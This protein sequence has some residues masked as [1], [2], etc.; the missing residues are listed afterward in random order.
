MPLFERNKVLITAGPTYEPIDPVRFI[1]NNSSGKMGFALAEAFAEAGAEVELI[2]GPV[3]LNISHPN[4]IRT[5]VMTAE[6]MYDACMQRFGRSDI[7]ILAAAV[8]DYRVK[9]PSEKKIKKTGGEDETLIL[10]LVKN[11]DI[12]ATLGDLKK[13]RQIL[14]GFSLETHNEL[15]FAREKMRKKNCDFM[16][17]NSLNDPGAGFGTDTN[18]ISILTEEQII[19]YPLR[20]K[21]E[22]AGD[23]VK[24]VFEKYFNQK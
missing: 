18:K 4:I 12:L 19:T 13:Q 8:A 7:A 3:H 10:E 9:N 5:D 16:V 2:A 11:K 23:I 22:V 14:G 17:M 1:G 24:F 6:E 15:S 21:T 20:S